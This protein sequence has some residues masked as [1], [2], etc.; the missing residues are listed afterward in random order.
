MEIEVIGQITNI[1]IIAVGNKISILPFLYRNFG[2]RYKSSFLPFVRRK[3]RW[4]KLKGIAQVKLNNG[5]IR[6]AEIHWF[7]ARGVGEIYLRI[8]NYLD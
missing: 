5:E 4:L 7:E 2:I 6:L 3:F 8:K 1:E